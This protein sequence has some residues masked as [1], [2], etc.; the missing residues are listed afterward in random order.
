MTGNQSKT[1]NRKDHA[2]HCTGNNTG[3]FFISS[4]E[5]APQNNFTLRVCGSWPKA[6]GGVS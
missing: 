2:G 3:I 5:S 4:E 6:A 1:E